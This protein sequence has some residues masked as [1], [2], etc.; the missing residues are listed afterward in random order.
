MNL[1]AVKN[2]GNFLSSW[3]PISFRRDMLHGMMEKD[4]KVIKTSMD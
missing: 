4:V 2:V 3:A 1:W